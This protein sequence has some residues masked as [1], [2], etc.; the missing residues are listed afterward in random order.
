VFGRAVFAELL[1][2]P[3]SEGARAVVRADP[4]R[5][6]EVP[7]R[8]P[9]IVDDIDTVDAYQDLLRRHAAGALPI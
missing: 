6:M 8:D 9:A 3:P 5:V 4:A 2:A 1:S 7:V